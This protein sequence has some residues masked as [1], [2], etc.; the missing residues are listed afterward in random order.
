MDYTNACEGVVEVPHS[1]QDVYPRKGYILG[2]VLVTSKA[3]A[4]PDVQVLKNLLHGMLV[5]TEENRIYV[6]VF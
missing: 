1:M 4:T 6:K 3:H 2:T 5:V